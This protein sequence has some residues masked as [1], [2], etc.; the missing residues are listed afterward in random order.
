MIVDTLKNH[1]LYPFGPAWEHA[2][3]FL[4]GLAPDTPEGRYTI[5]GDAIFAIV[6]SYETSAPEAGV[7]ES[8]RDYVDIQTV[9]AGGEGF[10]CAFADT[11]EVETPYD[12]SRDAA[13]YRRKVPGQSRVDV[14]PGTFVMLFPHDAHMAALMIGG[15]AERIKKVVVK[16]RAELLEAP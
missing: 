3:A 6:M 12:A 4:E 1:S 14:F 16:V 15:R 8:H 13:F 7:F 2:F 9:L 5:D 11:L 10:E